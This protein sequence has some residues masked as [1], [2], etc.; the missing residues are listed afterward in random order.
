MTAQPAKPKTFATAALTMA[1]L[2]VVF[3]DIGT[4]PLYTLTSCF[5]FSG[6][7]P[8]N[9]NDALGI[10][11]LLVWALILV[12]C[13][14]YLGCIMRVDHDG[15]G[16]ILALLALGTPQNSRRHPVATGLLTTIVVIGAAMLLGDGSITPAISVISAIE[17]IKPLAPTASSFI[18][19]LSVG[20]LIAMFAIQR[21]GTGYIGRIFGPIMFVWFASIAIAGGI[22]L[23]HEWVVLNALNPMY[24]IHFIQNHGL[25][26]FW[27]LGG[28]V[29]AITGVE[30]LYADLSHFGRKPIFFAWYG[31]VCPALMLCYLGE[32][33]AVIRNHAALSA[34]YYALTPGA[35]LV[36]SIL[37]ATIATIIA[38]QA[39]ISGAFT[40]VEQAIALGLAPRIRVLHT[41]AEQR[42][43]VYIPAVNTLLGVGCIALVIAFRESDRLAAAFGLAVSC[44]ML[45]TSIA[46][47]A[48]VTRR[49]MWPRSL[50]IIALAGFVCIDGAFVIAG[51][52]K[53]SDGGWV[54]F[55]VSAVLTL[56][57]LTWVWGRRSLAA[58]LREGDTPLADVLTT[59]ASLPAVSTPPI[60]MLAADPERVPLYGIHP[61]VTERVNAT[62]LVILHVEPVPVPRIPYQERVSVEH[63]G[64]RVTIVRARIGYME[65]PRIR[66]ILCA[67][68]ALDLDLTQPDIVFTY[69]QPVLEAHGRQSVTTKILTSIFSLML[70]NARRLS[71]DLEI[72]AQQRVGLGIA[73][74]L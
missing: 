47:F 49:K 19:P 38:S 13:V 61:W 8:S 28:V 27:G 36:P 37:L 9:L 56:L 1:A 48:V 53:F 31:T 24:G 41:S 20:I 26:G 14:K 39:L 44:T 35:W 60:V 18:V 51:L 25:S 6:A 23:S 74:K 62:A 2:G 12:V 42:G 17:G 34:P 15:E 40:L 16:G 5:A 55:L 52:P 30:A 70:R 72:P 67:C 11:S 64:P 7:S 58:A 3:G 29:L 21:F 46:W 45:A 71:D 68:H 65:P 10:A 4:S 73:V 66:P 22:S 43:Q 69:T 59:I 54:P 63:M 57:S 32:T 33:A 50:A